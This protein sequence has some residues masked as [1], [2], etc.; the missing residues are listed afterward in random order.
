MTFVKEEKTTAVTLL[1]VTQYHVLMVPQELNQNRCV[2]FPTTELEV[3]ETPEQ[4]VRRL[5]RR[6]LGEEFK[7]LAY[8]TSMLREDES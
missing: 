1:V 8:V 4:A 6:V 5:A 7:D 3:N 2:T